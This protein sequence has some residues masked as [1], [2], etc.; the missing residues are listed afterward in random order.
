[1]S[2]FQKPCPSCAASVAISATRC[3]CGHSFESAANNLS[4]LEATLRDE[5]L[6]EGYL[7]ARAE[8]ARQA[9]RRAEEVLAENTSN[10]EL[11][12]ACA[13]AREVAKSIDSDLAE[14][15]KKI[16]AI[17]NALHDLEP[18]AP[19]VPPAAK[20]ST[21][22]EK[23]V[24][25]QSPKT[26]VT[27]ARPSPIVTV[28]PIPVAAEK[29]LPVAAPA[30]PAPASVRHAATTQ[31]AAGVLAA[32]KNAKAREAVARAQQLKAAASAHGTVPPSA[33]RK[34]Q[35]SRAEKIM[36]A[37][38]TIDGKECPNCTSS[39]PVNT[40]RCR[41]GF[42][43]VSGGTELPSLTLCTGDF[44]ALRNSLKLNLR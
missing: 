2:I 26:P 25:R 34:E 22:R 17:R 38:K 16:A 27:T 1:M 41:C 43:F 33:F 9:A 6:Y 4:P 10:S 31:K 12:S 3:G 39:V 21:V 32:L 23:S 8:Q 11:V 18:V 5:E 42:A 14:Q 40:T 44:T 37:R 15:Q 36:E 7:A 20:P 28:S 30:K 24:S 19:V 35:A 29:T 13:L